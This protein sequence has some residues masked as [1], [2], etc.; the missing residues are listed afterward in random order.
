VFVFASLLS[1]CITLS[2]TPKRIRLLPLFDYWAEDQTE[3]LDVAGPLYSYQRTGGERKWA[4]RP[5]ISKYEDRE[6]GVCEY[7]FLYP[8]GRYKRTKDERLIRFIPLI[9]SGK[10][11]EEEE[12][13]RISEFFPV[14]WG[15]TEEGE[16]YGGVIPFYGN[17]KK[18]FGRD[19]ITFFLWPLYSSSREGETRTYKFIWPFLAYTKGKDRRA[20]RFWPFYG[21]DDKEGLYSKRFVFWPFFIQQKTDLDTNTPKDFF[22]LFPFY[23]SSN[24][25]TERSRTILFPLFTSYRKDNFRQRTYPWPLLTHAKGIDYESRNVLPFYRYQRSAK[26]RYFY[27]MWPIYKHELEWDKNRTVTDHLFLINKFERTSFENENKVAKTYRFWPLFYYRARKNGDVRFDFP[28]LIPAEYEGFDRNYGPLF[29][30]FEYRKDAEGNV[31]SKFLWGLYT[32]RKRSSKESKDMTIIASYEK[33]QGLKSFS[34]LKGLLDYRSKD[35]VSSLGFLYL[36][37]RIEWK[38]AK[39]SPEF[40]EDSTGGSF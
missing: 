25:G 15:R 7:E 27:V 40:C 13:G 18:S 2:S 30:V 37:W 21:Q 26:S 17:L 19:E 4:F 11:F 33:D 38:R 34:L 24:S 29:R 35:N 9:K 12:R 1:G 31:Q 22:A 5:F 23:I 36:P 28:G 14:F 10:S 20:F 16:R 8:L 32:H 3:A 39:A 6:N